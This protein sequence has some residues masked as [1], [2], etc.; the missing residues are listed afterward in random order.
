MIVK[1]FGLGGIEA[2]LRHPRLD[3]ERDAGG[4][5]AARGVDRDYVGHETEV[6][7]ILD[8]LAPGRTLSGDDQRIVVGRHQHGTA[9]AR[10]LARDRFAVLTGAIVQHDFG[11]ERSGALA[12]GPRRVRGHDDH[13]RHA[14]QCRRRRHALRM[15]AGGK[16]DHAAGALGRRDGGKAIIGAAELERAG[17]LQRFRLEKDAR[18]RERVEHRRGHQRRAQGDAGEPPRGSVDVG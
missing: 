1:T 9:R 15:V 3:R 7:Q 13:G 16:R 11:A 10:K 8:D 2:G 5:P 4:E 14:Q 12:L 18:A 6:G 17:A